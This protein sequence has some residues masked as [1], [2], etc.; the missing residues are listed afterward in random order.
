MKN[1]IQFMIG[2][3]IVLV[4]KVVLHIVLIT[5]LQKLKLIQIK[6]IQTD[7]NNSLPRNMILTF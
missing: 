5:I 6:L 3:I 4:K 1:I 2:L 7:S